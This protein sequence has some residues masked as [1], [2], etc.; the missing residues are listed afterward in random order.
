MWSGKLALG[1]LKSEDR[2]LVVEGRL[3]VLKPLLQSPAI[4]FLA[5]EQEGETGEEEDAEGD[6]Y[7]GADG[8]GVCD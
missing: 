2:A 7:T 6:A 1:V 3:Q 8:S 4:P 5:V